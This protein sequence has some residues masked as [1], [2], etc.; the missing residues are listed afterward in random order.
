MMIVDKQA[1]EIRTLRSIRGMK[2]VT[3]L[4]ST[5]ISKA[6]QSYRGFFMQ[7]YRSFFMRLAFSKLLLLFDI[8]FIPRTCNRALPQ[9]RTTL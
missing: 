9:T 4:I 1:A 7:S 5:L 6:L 3:I 8:F 2:A